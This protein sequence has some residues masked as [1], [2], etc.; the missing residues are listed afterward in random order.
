MNVSV[1]SVSFIPVCLT[2]LIEEHN[3]KIKP[4][5]KSF[6][7]NSI[8]YDNDDIFKCCSV[9][10]TDNDYIFTFFAPAQIISKLINCEIKI[11]MYSGN[12]KVC[13]KNFIPDYDYNIVIQMYNS[14]TACDMPDNSLIQLYTLQNSNLN[15]S[16]LTAM[17]L[18]EVNFSEINSEDLNSETITKP[19]KR[20]RKY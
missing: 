16:S 19:Y 13:R 8:T 7:Y 15:T 1:L 11:G 10:K 20:K 6:T 4:V 2:F 14:L 17:Y 18:K 12:I 9:T 5:I 3:G